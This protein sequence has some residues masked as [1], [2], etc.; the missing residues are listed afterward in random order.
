MSARDEVLTAS[1]IDMLVPAINTPSASPKF[2]LNE[3][4]SID[5]ADHAVWVHDLKNTWLGDAN[6]DAEFNG[7]DF[8][9]VVKAN[10]YEMHVNA[11]WAEGDWN[12]DQ[13]FDSGDFVAAFVDGGCESSVRTAADAIPEPSSALLLGLG[14]ALIVLSYRNWRSNPR[15]VKRQNPTP[16]VSPT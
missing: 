1:D 11:D 5:L 4:G 3:D 12:A 15:S 8:V 6:L 16:T 7:G 2:D 9:E 13:R 14:V 10:K